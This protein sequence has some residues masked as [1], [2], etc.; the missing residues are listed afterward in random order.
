MRSALLAQVLI[1]FLFAEFCYAQVTA[2]TIRG[3]V[4]DSSGA[5]V[6]NVEVR[7]THLG[8]GQVLTS[9]TTDAGLYLVGNAPV[10]E[11]KI[12][13]EV[14]GFK[15][16]V[17]Q[18]ITVGTATTTNLDISLEVG[19]AAETVTVEGGYTP[20]LQ[21]DNSEVSTVMEQKLVI[22]LPMDLGGRSSAGGASGRR[23]IETF[24]FLTPGVTGDLWNKHFLGSPQH[25]AQSVIDGIPLSIQESPGRT[26]QVG[27]P[28]EAVQEFK[29][30]TT[31]YSA[32]QGRG[33]GIANYTLKSG[34]N[35]FHGNAFWFLRNDKLDARGFFRTARPITR[36]NEY[37][38]TFGGPILKNKLFFY[39]A[40]TGF[41]R[42][43]GALSS[44]LTTIPA[45]DFRQGNFSRLVDGASVQIPLFDPATT[46]SVGTSFMRQPFAGN[47][48]P[49]ARFS[50]V[51]VDALKDMPAPDNPGIVNN[52]VNR[53]QEPTNDDVWS[54]KGDYNLTSRQHL[55]FSYWWVR[56]NQIR[57]STWGVNPVDTG[58]IENHRGGGLRA[59]YDF[60]IRPTLLNH[61]A[62]GYSR[63]NKDRL[64][65]FP[66]SG[67]VLSIPNI[68]SDAIQ[69]PLFAPGGYLSWGGAGAGPDIT[70]DDANIFTDTLSWIKGKHSI[71]AGGEYWKQAFSRFDGRNIAGTFNFDRL[72]TSQP[73][74]PLFSAWGDG[75]ASF[76]LG[77]V[78][79]G[80]FKVNPTIPTYDTH[81]LAFFLEDKIQVSKKLTLSLGIRYEVPWPINERDD[82]I[83]GVDLNLPNAAAGGRLGAF[84]FGNKAVGPKL[85]TFEWSPRIAL[86]YQFDRKTVVRSGFGIIYA[87]ANALVSGT[88]LNG[89][90]L[91]A[92]FTGT[93]NPVTLN[94][95]ITPAFKLDAGPPPPATQFP[96][97]SPTINVGGIGDY[98]NASSGMAPYTVSY[99]FTIQR[100]LPWGIYTD[101]AYVGAKS[102]HLPANLENRNQVPVG[103]LGLGALLNANISSAAAIAAGIPSPYPGFNGSVAQALRPYPQYTALVPHSSP[104]GNSTYQSFQ[105]KIQKR[106]S[107][108][109]SFL[110]S[111]TLSKT[112]TDTSGNAW[113]TSEPFPRDAANLGL[114]KAVAP[115]DNTHNVVANFVYELPGRSLK[116]IKGALLRGWQVGGTVVYTSGPVIAISGGP[117]LPLFGG[118]NRPSRVS[119]VD[120]FTGVDKGD[121]DPARDRLLNVSAWR[122]PANF[123]IGDGSR[124]EPDL[125]GF[126]FWNESMTF[127]KRTYIPAINETCNVEIRSEFFNLTNRVVFSN[128]AS[129]INTTNTFGVVS[130]QANSPRTIQFGLK[131]NF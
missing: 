115:F 41:K 90:A 125:R 37:G 55:S 100:E 80:T 3:V 113:S 34:T 124:T 44:S 18:P 119:G 108:G 59:N 71:K 120:R 52:W 116:G 128:P 85:Q 64:P 47:L 51:A 16:I 95:G 99:N 96:N 35:D 40:Y 103:Y 14:P 13:I 86:A 22:D 118:A 9:R 127:M 72:S 29:V 112:I 19:N 89:N 97:L 129:N 17:Q 67:N 11:Y 56:L 123:T 54:A 106:Y 130:G 110:T 66:V 4:T 83:S 109:L 70:R 63:Q 62:W 111:Y 49:S 21:I 114:E 93:S 98:L 2:G 61:L 69:F 8:T 87:Q 7:A 88:E 43:G 104:I 73:N 92:G 84:V 36:Q 102:T 28:V 32:D 15:R 101:V 58:Y 57:Y 94:Q 105:A 60:I 45:T 68:P 42:R 91:L 131:F 48:I 12:E 1:A 126:T 107:S 82:L 75:F 121:F 65:A 39:A 10:G 31:L 25:T 81:Y 27:P 6:P 76:L 26:S 33:F 122:Q 79:S 38:A 5:T 46:T 30:S 78:S 53:T 77:E 20:L 24:I 23:Q 74:S 50:R 117:A